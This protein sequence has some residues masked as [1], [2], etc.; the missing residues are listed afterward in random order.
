MCAALYLE[1]PSAGTQVNTL[2]RNH[3]AGDNADGHP[4]LDRG[5]GFLDIALLGL[6]FE[7]TAALLVVV[8]DQLSETRKVL[9]LSSAGA[10]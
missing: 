7:V 1:K 9:D 2:P 8:N 10:A 4:T 6:V 3:V 5:F